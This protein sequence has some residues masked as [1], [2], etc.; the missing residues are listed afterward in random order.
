MREL[1]KMGEQII[2]SYEEEMSCE[3]TE[4]PLPNGRP[5]ESAGSSTAY[6]RAR[7]AP[8]AAQ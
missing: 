4:D 1:K 6:E 2:L 8:P 7:L 3:E 5:Q